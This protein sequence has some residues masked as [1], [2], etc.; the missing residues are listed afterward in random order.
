MVVL[1]FSS[2]FIHLVGCCR[3][4][5]NFCHIGMNLK[6]RVENQDLVFTS[7][8]IRALGLNYCLEYMYLKCIIYYNDD[9]VLEAIFYCTNNNTG[10]P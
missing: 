3:M 1:F 6:R 5:L 7:R 8:F 9:N 2:E 10:N 4:P